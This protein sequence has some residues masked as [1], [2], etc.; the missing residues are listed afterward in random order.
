MSNVMDVLR[1]RGYIKQTTF[2]DD[3]YQMLEKERVTF[4]VGFDLDRRQPAH[5]SLYPGDGDDPSAA[6]RPS[7]YRPG[8]RWYRYGGRS[9]RP[10]R[11]AQNANAGGCGP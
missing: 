8:R 7:A 9:F 2:E 3:L 5:R 10:Y 6:G 11:Y 4:Y 1:E